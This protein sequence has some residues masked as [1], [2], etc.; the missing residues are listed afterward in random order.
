MKKSSK[1]I[2][3]VCVILSAIAIIIS[4]MITSVGDKKKKVGTRNNTNTSEDSV[5][6]AIKYDTTSAVYEINGTNHTITV[7]Q[8]FPTVIA[9][10]ESVQ[11]KMQS[12]LGEIANNEFSEFKRYVEQIISDKYEVNAEYMESVGDLSLS[13][14]F[15]N[16][17]NDEK[18]VSVENESKGNLSGISWPSKRGYSFNAQTGELLKLEDIAISKE[19][20]RKYINETIMK[21]LKAN[22]QKLGLNN[23]V[24]SNLT[25]LANIDNL[26]WYLSDSGL[27]ICFEKGTFSD[28]AFSY[29]INYSSLEEYVTAEYL[30]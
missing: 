7:N 26:Y 2:I 8:D 11:N 28:N 15:S 4:S 30:K 16:S 10:D 29:T 18:V 20:L 21:Y 6:V 25:K 24:M 23:N 12:I 17:R 1:I 22:Y 13:W 19:A 9:K 14:K 5:Y 3:I 27:T